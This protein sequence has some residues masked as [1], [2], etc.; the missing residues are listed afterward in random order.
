MTLE[1]P[2]FTLPLGPMPGG[3]ALRR[4]AHYVPANAAGV[5]DCSP[6]DSF[7]RIHWK[8]TARRDRLIVKEFELDPLSDIWIFLDGDRDA[9]A[10]LPDGQGAEPGEGTPLWVGKRAKVTLPPS[11][12]EY[13][14]SVAATL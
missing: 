9:Q 6:G 2:A 8:S 14:V 1:L 13:A 3:E 11:T 5:R 7:N 12:E 10:S 4:G